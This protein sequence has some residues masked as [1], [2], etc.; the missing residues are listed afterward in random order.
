MIIAVDFDGTIV[1]H[2]FPDIGAPCPGAFEWLRKFKEAG[3]SLIL[4]TMRSA[5]RRKGGDVLAPAVEFCRERGV[6]FIGVNENPTQKE[7]TASP[8]AYAHLYIDDAAFGCPLRVNPR[9]D[10]RPFVD[11]DVVGPAVIK[12]IEAESAPSASSKC[13]RCDGTG[14]VCDVCGEAEG[15]CE[16]EEF[17]TGECP[18]CEGGGT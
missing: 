1:D 5:D 13:F 9:M 18:D 11:W 7:W 3:A 14:E 4:W 16:C 17:D 2:R 12:M 10:G 8:K 6:E 15:A